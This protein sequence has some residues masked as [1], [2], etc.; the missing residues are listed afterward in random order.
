MHG[1]YQSLKAIIL[2]HGDLSPG[3]PCAEGVSGPSRAGGVGPDVG[4]PPPSVAH[5]VRRRALPTRHSL[6]EECHL[7]TLPGALGPVWS[8]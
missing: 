2:A 3:E 5:H 1:R 7:L 4:S 6:P 8:K